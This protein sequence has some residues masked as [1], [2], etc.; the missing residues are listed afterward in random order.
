MLVME[1]LRDWADKSKNSALNPRD[2]YDE[3]SLKSDYRYSL[4]FLLISS[5]LGGGSLAGIIALIGNLNSLVAAVANS[6]TAGLLFGFLA[7]LFFLAETLMTHVCLRFLGATKDLKTTFE[8]MT[9]PSLI[10]MVLWWVPGLNILMGIYYLYVSTIGLA[11]IQGISSARA[12]ISLL[13]GNVLSWI[14]I[15]VLL[16]LLAGFVGGLGALLGL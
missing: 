4:S 9:Y 10:V 6:I 14:P 3:L 13:L 15:I 2:F 1:L 5:I 11:K 8:V 7:A 16:L 12:L